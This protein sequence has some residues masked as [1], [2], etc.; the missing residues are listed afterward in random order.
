MVIGRPAGDTSAVET[1]L[2]RLVSSVGQLLDHHRRVL[3][4]IDGPD[5][6][7]KTTLADRLAAEIGTHTLRASIDSFHNPARIRGNRGDLSPE[8]YYRDSF[9]YPSVVDDLLEPFARGDTRVTTGRYNH[10]NDMPAEV[11]VA[12]VS[13][14]AVLVFDGVF[15][16]REELRPYWTF[17]I[18]LTVTPAETV[19]RALLRDGNLGRED[20]L[21]RRYGARYLPGQALYRSEAAPE[22]R[23]H[24]VVDNNDPAAPV[25]LRWSIP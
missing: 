6:A 21:E 2:G 19:R 13:A 10:L 20:E 25:V 16:L 14:E 11:A 15:L 23:A 5:A 12:G 3:V 18:Y 22:S 17:A 4:G 24:V 8:G 9:D 1:L 7:G